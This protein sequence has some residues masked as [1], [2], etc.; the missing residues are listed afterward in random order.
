MV[1]A[2][3]ARFFQRPAA[4]I[5]GKSASEFFS[6]ETARAIVQHN[7]QVLSDGKTRTFELT[8]E[9]PCG[10]IRILSTKGVF[11]D[12]Q[13]QILGIF[14][15]ARDITELYRAKDAQRLLACIVESSNDAIFSLTPDLI[16]T[17]WNQGAE[18]LYGYSAAEMV[19][20]HIKTIIPPDRIEE[21]NALNMKAEG[22]A[23]IRH[24][25]TRRRT[26]QGRL[27]DMD[28]TISPMKNDSGEL[29]GRA[30]IA[31]DITDLKKL[32]RE[33]LEIIDCERERIGQDLHDQVCQTL[34]GIS[35]LAGALQ[36][37]L[38]KNPP[39]KRKT[40]SGFATS[41]GRLAPRRVRWRRD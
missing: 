8:M 20:R 33:I 3:A 36:G 35:L 12:L 16:V 21:I 11:R 18:F 32:E 38:A 17:S 28:L 30:V 5:I 4:E 6:P 7:H 26:K 31:H 40:P 41:H 13:G 39:W 9:M 23:V 34:A 14:G 29:I 2:A 1:N 10:E 15:I 19:G 25:E 24:F 27:L 37:R 22:G